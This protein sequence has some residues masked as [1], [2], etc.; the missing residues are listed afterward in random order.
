MSG[1]NGAANPD[2]GAQV[3]LY[4]A[5]LLGCAVSLSFLGIGLFPDRLGIDDAPLLLR[6]VVGVFGAFLLVCTLFAFRHGVRVWQAL[7]TAPVNPDRVEL[8]VEDS[9]DST[10]YT[11]IVHLGEETWAV[12]AYAGK[13]LRLIERGIA[14]EIRAW[15]D[16]KNGAPIAFSVDGK[17]VETYPHVMQR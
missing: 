14:Q 7:R 9:S 1:D 6:V 13:G 2:L 11:L 10:S 5:S 3:I 16:P 12:P 17:R 4:V 8:E 15:R